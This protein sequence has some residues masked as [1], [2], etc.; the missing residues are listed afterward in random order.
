MGRGA[1][2]AFQPAGFSAREG[3]SFALTLIPTCIEIQRTKRAHMAPGMVENVNV[4]V[5]RKFHMKKATSC[6]LQLREVRCTTM[7]LAC[8]RK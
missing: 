4:P 7:L 6:S 3:D 1:V 8:V 5:R 2:L